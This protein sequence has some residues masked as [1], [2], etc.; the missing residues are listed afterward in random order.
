[1]ALA[2][3][4]GSVLRRRTASGWVLAALALGSVALMACRGQLDCEEADQA[5]QALLEEYGSCANGEACRVY[6]IPDS[7]AQA[8][9][10]GGT[11]IDALLCSVALRQD[12]NEAAFLD[13]ARDIVGRRHCR[14]CAIA[15]CRQPAGLQA[16]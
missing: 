4:A 1:M 12:A 11:C 3:T 6:S 9:E 16:F 7:L 15:K 2:G 8:N 13:R 5:A 14:T 10:A